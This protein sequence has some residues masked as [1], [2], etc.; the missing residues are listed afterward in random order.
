MYDKISYISYDKS[1]QAATLSRLGE[2]DHIHCCIK[3]KS[4][5][6]RCN[7]PIPIYLNRFY[8]IQSKNIP[9]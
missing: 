9:L 7:I 3:G 2:G 5:V 6:R 4:I 8:S 1:V